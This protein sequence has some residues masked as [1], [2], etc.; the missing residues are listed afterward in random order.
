MER[1]RSPS[2][3]ISHWLTRVLVWE[4]GVAILFGALFGYL[5]G[6]LLEWAENQHTIERVSFLGYTALSITVL[7]AAKLFG[8]D[9]IL[10][11]FV[12][13]LIFSDVV[14]G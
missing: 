3:A 5:A 9:G 7:G 8:T 10:A 1:A 6:R 14:S 2:E 4:V 13:G 11:V 12:A